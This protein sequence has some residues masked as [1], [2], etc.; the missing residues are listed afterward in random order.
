MSPISKT[1]LQD[2]GRKLR[3]VEF[4][5]TVFRDK[6]TSLEPHIMVEISSTKSLDS[7]SLLN[8]LFQESSCSLEGLISLRDITISPLH[9]IFPTDNLQTIR[10][11]VEPILF[12]ISDN[13]TVAISILEEVYF[14]EPEK[15][16]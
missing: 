9:T 15:F 5:E 3:F 12:E 11:Q 8:V 4:V 6:N 7:C 10:R 16:I 13:G 14:Y 2:L 1:A